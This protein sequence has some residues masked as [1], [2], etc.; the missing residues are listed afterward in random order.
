MYSILILDLLAGN[1][2]YLLYL[3]I[4]IFLAGNII[5]LLYL[6]IPILL[7]GNIIYLLYLCDSLFQ[8]ARLN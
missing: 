7:A 1:S 4:P 8:G 6:S 5:Y 3:S 2:I